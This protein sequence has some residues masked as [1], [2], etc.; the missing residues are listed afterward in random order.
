LAPGYPLGM[1]RLPTPIRALTAVVPLALAGCGFHTPPTLSVAE[2][3]YAESEDGGAVVTLVMEAENTESEP[4][5][6]GVAT[7]EFLINGETAYEGTWDAQATAPALGSVRF[8]LP[9]PI[10]RAR[11]AGAEPPSYALRGVVEYV[12]PGALGE[13]LFDTRIRRGSAAFRERGTLER[14]VDRQGGE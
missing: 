5:P 10:D 9:A 3:K 11:L 7:Y 14:P 8:E 1:T 13:A 4:M 2:L 6:F 12:P